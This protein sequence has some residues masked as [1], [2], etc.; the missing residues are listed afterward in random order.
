MTQLGSTLPLSAML[1]LPV[2]LLLELQKDQIGFSKNYNNWTWLYKCTYE[3][4]LW[5]LEVRF[6][7]TKLDFLKNYNIRTWRYLHSHSLW[8]LEV[9]LKNNNI[10]TWLYL[11]SLTLAEVFRVVSAL[12]LSPT[13]SWK[14]FRTRYHSVADLLITRSDPPRA[15]SRIYSASKA[16]DRWYLAVSS[17]SAN[18]WAHS[19]LSTIRQKLSL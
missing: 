13:L 18:S 15:I 2:P 3:Y 9:G 7:K 4:S 8:P 17:K 5:P 6:K 10:R 19:A 1:T 16:W 12:Q 11:Q 14:E